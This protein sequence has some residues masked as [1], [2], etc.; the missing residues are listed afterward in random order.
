MEMSPFV[1]Y[2][3][4]LGAAIGAVLVPALLNRS[5]D[6][7]ELTAGCKLLSTAGAAIVGFMWGLACGEVF[8]LCLSAF[9]DGLYRL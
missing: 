4:I 7:K 5:N 3:M 2:G 1:H 9:V 6:V 8:G